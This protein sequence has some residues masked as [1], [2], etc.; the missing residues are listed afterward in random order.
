RGLLVRGGPEPG[1]L[2]PLASLLGAVPVR[3]LDL[4]AGETVSPGALV[5]FR[6]PVGFVLGTRGGIAGPE[7]DSALV[8]ELPAPTPGERR[9]IW[10]TGLRAVGAG[11]RP[12]D[13]D[14]IARGHRMARGYI[15][16]AAGWAAGVARLDG[17][18]E[19][20]PPDVARAVGALGREKLEGLAT[21]VAVG[22]P[23][24]EPLVLDARAGRAFADLVRRCL[25]R[26]ELPAVAG[27]ALAARLRPGVKTLFAGPSGSGKTLAARHLA[28]LLGMELYRADLAGLIDKHLGE[29]EKRCD[30]LFAHAE[31]LDVMLVLDEG[32]A[33]M[34]RRTDVRSSNDRY[35]NLETN[36][37]LQRLEDY[38]GILV[39]TTNAPERIDD[40]FRRRLDAVVEFRPPDAGERWAIWRAHLPAG[41]AAGDGWLE[42][43]ATRCPLSG[44]QI[45]NAVLHAVLLALEAGGPV[46]EMHL[47]AAVR[48]EYDQAGGICPLGPESAPLGEY[49]ELGG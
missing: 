4:A 28:G 27:P 25:R 5:G 6:R 37:L 30:A 20:T 33:V 45:R 35:A 34:A 9:A 22:D 46:G 39:V 21:R 49:H 13:L 31:A 29:F 24:S 41:H 23:G 2:G 43:V 26:E 14:A 7:A 40:A 8:V 17:R 16:R 38:D 12:A 3:R 15:P 36:F 1:L 10:H 44:G 18:I 19:V 32:D 47:T 42:R 11:C 48:R